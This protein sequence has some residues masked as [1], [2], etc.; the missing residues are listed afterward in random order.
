MCTIGVW[1]SDSKTYGINLTLSSVIHFGFGNATGLHQG[2]EGSDSKPY[3]F[4]LK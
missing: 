1:G 3:G 2:R 4:N